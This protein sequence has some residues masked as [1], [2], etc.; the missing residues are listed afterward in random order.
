MRDRTIVDKLIEA[1]NR[2][3]EKN[4]H[5]GTWTD[6]SDEEVLVSLSEKLNELTE[7]VGKLD[8]L[9]AINEAAGIALFAA[10]YADPKRVLNAN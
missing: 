9:N 3:F 8:M 7:S 2:K 5:K 10:F 6:M 4:E 1:I